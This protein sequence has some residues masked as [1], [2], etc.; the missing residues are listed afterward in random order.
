[1]KHINLLIISLFCFPFLG[2]DT[3]RESAKPQPVKIRKQAIRPTIEQQIQLKRNELI[4]VN[5]KIEL[6]L[7]E[8][9]NGN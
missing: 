4:R 1:M 2:M 3:M 5:S 9:K 7:A 8:I 6:S